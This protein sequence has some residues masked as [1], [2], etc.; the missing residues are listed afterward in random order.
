MTKGKFYGRFYKTEINPHNHT[1]I[2]ER[3]LR[4]TLEKTPLISM[5]RTIFRPTKVRRKGKAIENK[6]FN[7]IHL[8]EHQKFPQKPPKMKLPKGLSTKNKTNKTNNKKTH[9]EVYL[10]PPKTRPP[11]N[12]GRK[13]KNIFSAVSN[14]EPMLK[15]IITSKWRSN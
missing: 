7:D 13:C 14:T 5:E 3:A 2:L 8:R 9:S 11:T 10:R 1:T 12:T 6:L 4:L 15:E